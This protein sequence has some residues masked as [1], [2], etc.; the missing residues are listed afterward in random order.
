[1]C[2][3]SLRRISASPPQTAATYTLCEET[4]MIMGDM[5]ISGR[6]KSYENKKSK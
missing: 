6:W 4:Q 5:K 1:M 3:C 2:C